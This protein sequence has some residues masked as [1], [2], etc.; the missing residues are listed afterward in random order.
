MAEDQDD[1]KSSKMKS[2]SKGNAGGKNKEGGK[3]K[4]KN[5][6]NSLLA[7]VRK[8][9]RDQLRGSGVSDEQ[10][11]EKMKSHMKD[12]VRPAVNAAK[13]SAEGKNLTGQDRRKFVQDAVRSKLGLTGE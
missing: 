1:K 10:I 6:K 2:K 3:G 4:N 11:K 5:K 7:A 12:V 13:T 9:Y 8:Q